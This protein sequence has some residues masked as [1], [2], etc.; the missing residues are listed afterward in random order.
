MPAGVRKKHDRGH[1]GTGLTG[2]PRR[3]TYPGRW[4]AGSTP[5][6]G[7]SLL[8]QP[9]AHYPHPQ[10][11][12]HHNLRSWAFLER[13]HLAHMNRS[14]GWG[15]FSLRRLAF[16]LRLYAGRR[17]VACM[18]IND[19]RERREALG[20]TQLELAGLAGIRPETLSRYERGVRVRPNRRLL[21]QLLHAL[22]DAEARANA[23]GEAA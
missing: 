2:S 17:I 13:R 11:P 14:Y 12:I 5:P 19:I 4:H 3:A 23:G 10:L 22:E 9:P 1:G 8:A 7:A 21:R 20:L 6:G 15:R 18:D 16:R